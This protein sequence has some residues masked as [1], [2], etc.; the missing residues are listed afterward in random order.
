MLYT[1]YTIHAINYRLQHTLRHKNKRNSYNHKV[2]T[3]S[4][5]PTNEGETDKEKY[6]ERGGKERY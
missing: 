4:S 6:I 2:F 5:E 3:I 1:V